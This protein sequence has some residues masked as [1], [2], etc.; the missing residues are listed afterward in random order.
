MPVLPSQLPGN[1][2][3][4]QVATCEW[5]GILL[6]CFEMMT[7]ILPLRR[8]TQERLLQMLPVL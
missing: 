2:P 4:L 5:A 3:A 8:L 7:L 1:D 6:G